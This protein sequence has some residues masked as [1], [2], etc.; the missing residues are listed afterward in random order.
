MHREWRGLLAAGVA[1][2]LG[3]VGCATAPATGRSSGSVPAAA[4]NHGTEAPPAD[5]AA[6]EFP[7][8]PFP[9]TY[10]A[11]P[12]KTT[13][14]RHAH[15]YTGTGGELVSGDVLMRDGKIA[16]VGERVDAP[17]DA[18]AIDGS[19][20]FVT[21]G[22]IDVHSHLGVYPSPQVDA[23][24]NGNE[25]TNP[26]TAEVRAENSVWPQDE[27]FN[28]AR[29]GGVTTLEI[30]PGSG[31]LIG[32]LSVVL[33][34]VPSRTVEGMKFPGAP[35][36][37]KMAC[38]EN[39]KRVYGSRKQFPSTEMGNVAGYRQAWADAQD[40]DAKWKAWEKEK[41]GAP[42]RRDLRLETLAGV[43]AGCIRVQMHCYRCD[44]MATML[45]V[46]KEFHY[47]IAAFHHAV[48]AYKL[49]DL[50]K[51]SG[52]CAAMWADWW[53]F[54]IEAWDG[55]VENLPMVD[56]GG[57]CAM[58]HSDSESGIQRLNQEVAK[59]WGAGRRAGLD[60][61]EARAIA[62]MTSNPAK[63]LGIDDRTGSLAPG[64]MAD[65]VLWSADPFSV[66]AKA[67]KV[68]V[69]GALVYDR[70]DPVRQPES[71]FSLGSLP[72]GGSR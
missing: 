7:P 59:A 26:D 37:L 36:G 43:L 8:D 48:E 24:A 19:G 5:S 29:A 6:A 32:G 53:G 30:L 31:N 64:K 12:S 11:L 45:E 21:P 14:I 4:A 3:G 23:L 46:A 38:G 68:F 16:A 41:K 2:I 72:R 40:Y 66:Y 69:D 15:V 42:P 18:V 10:V 20:K 25:L 34:N 67:E 35:Y 17:A 70:E 58:I 71:D 44:E 28:A 27:G 9:S 51:A 62:W 61:P 47:H 1:L 60:I 33:K 39:P 65:V 63:A 55:I 13:V 50:L 54:K 57:A 22:I 56:A 52:T 49:P